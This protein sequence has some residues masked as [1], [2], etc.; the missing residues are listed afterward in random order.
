LLLET[1]APL[2]RAVFI[3]R[4][5]FGYHVIISGASSTSPQSGAVRRGLRALG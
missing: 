4:E 2:E 5:V 1:V 3:L